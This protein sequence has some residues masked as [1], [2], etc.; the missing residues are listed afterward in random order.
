MKVRI[1]ID[2]GGTFTDAIAIDNST[3]ELIGAVKMPTT[4]TAKEGVAAGIILVL[5]EILEKYSI[6][7]EDV[8]FIAHGT[9]QAT[10]ALL[11]GDVARVGI[12]AMGSGVEGYKVRADSKVGKIELADGKYLNTSHKFISNA[13]K[14]MN[15]TVKDG[16]DS[17]VAEKSEVIV[18]TEAF[19]VDNPEN[20]NLAVTIA[21]SLGIPATAGN[22]VSKLYGLKTRTRTA[23]INGSILPK[24]LSTANMTESSIA[25]TNISSPLM[26][27]RCDG[28]VMSMEE[29]R[30]RPI[31][32]I[33]SGPAAGVAGALMYEKLTDG[34]FLEV[35]GTSTDIS[36]VRDGSVMIRYAEIGGHKTYINS[37]DVRTVGIGGGSMV[38]LKKDVA[39]GCGPRSAHIAD[40]KY[41]VY[42]SEDEIIDPQLRTI[43]PR[44]DDPEYAYI[45]CADGKSFALTLSGAANIAG[46]VEENDYARGNVAAAVKAWEPLAKNMNLTVKECAVKVLEFAAEKNAKIVDELVK[47]YGLDMQSVVLVG[48]GGGASS[49]VPFLSK[50]LGCKFR[51]AKNAQVISPIGVAMALVRDMVERTVAKPTEQDVI[52][53]REE[54]FTKA[55][56]SGAAPDSVEVKIEINARE[57]KLRAV[58]I[59]A[60]ELR[61][62][63]ISGTKKTEAQLISIVADNAKVEPES[64]KTVA[65]NG[66]YYAMQ[67]SRKIKSFIF[68]KKNINSVRLVDTDGIIRIQRKDGFI[69]SCKAKDAVRFLNN[70]VDEYTITGDGGDE[71]PN[72]FIATESRIIDLSGMQN[73]KQLEALAQTELSGSD[74]T[75]TIL[76]LCTYKTSNERA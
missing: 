59:G 13:S 31:L 7:P 20:E 3:Y 29:V 32:T 46:Y 27:M 21:S 58:A 72:I 42:A 28:G 76:F 17:L 54:A 12:L 25:K 66:K 63:D 62:K 8:V 61:T 18:A 51:I 71:T 44:P 56:R 52:S 39:I 33:L 41:E 9:T 60:T 43:R 26:I 67:F 36:C 57:N 65:N 14:N 40:L 15:D 75:D 6:S 19:S 69:H 50:K 4:H 73:K 30:K 37:L 68:F 35:G 23:V 5:K 10:N 47:N 11:E 2:V 55:V 1:G 74:P 22:D 16:I 64:V 49:V 24:M 34:I 38:L 70:I 53:I 48:G 45:K